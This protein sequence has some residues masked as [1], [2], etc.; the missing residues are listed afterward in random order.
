MNKTHIKEIPCLDLTKARLGTKQDQYNT[1]M[2]MDKICKEIGFFT[3]IGHGTPLQ[4]FEDI[5]SSMD[6]FFSLP[7]AHKNKCRLAEGFT[8]AS[9]DYTP[10]GYSGLLEENAYAYMGEHGKPSDYVEKFSVSKEIFN[11]EIMLPFP[12]ND[13]GKQFREKIKPYYKACEDLA[14]LLT[15][16]FA[17]ALDL[18]PD[19][20]VNRINN[21]TDSMRLHNYPGFQQDFVNKQGMAE[22]KDGTLIT[23]LTNH[24]PGIEVKTSSGEWIKPVMN[25]LDCFLVNIGDLM[26]RWSNNT[27]LSTV[28][29]VVLSNEKRQSI[30][31]FKLANDDTI[32]ESFPKF[33]KNKVSKYNPIIYKE[34]SLEKMNSLFHR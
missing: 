13:Q 15:N 24:T 32:I 20:F 3:V 27:Y 18:P 34:F 1:A 6:T 19:F 4:V 31:F 8:R 12:K 7:L 2:E 26:M 9:D 30:A 10:L 22:H 16:L 14:S 25:N 23:L 21:S 33:C 11:D 28:H 5:Y 29:R 17:L